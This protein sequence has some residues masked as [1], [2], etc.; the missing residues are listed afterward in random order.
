MA[1]MISLRLLRLVAVLWVVSV[2]TYL[3][4]DLIPGDPVLT[5]LGTSATPQSIAYLHQQLGL[6]KP[7][8]TR[9][10]DWIGGVLH[11][12][13][14]STLT[15]PHEPVSH[16]LARAFPVTLEIVVLALVFSVLVALPLGAWAAYRN[17]SLF[18]RAL[19]S[20]SFALV[21]L[22][23]FVLG[24]LLVL[25]FVLHGSA[26]RTGLLV[27]FCL[28]AMSVLRKLT[29]AASWHSRS[30]RLCSAGA[31]VAIGLWLFVVLPPFPSEGWVALTADPL[32]NLKFAFLPSLT[33]ALGLIPLFAQI[34]RTDM[35]GTF[36]Q[37]FITIARAK[38]MPP[39][40]VVFKEALRPSLFSL[41][42]VAGISFGALL[43]GTVVVEALFN[44]PG[45]GSA[46]VSSIGAKDYP[47]VLGA[48]IVLA[49]VF[50]VMN[51]LVDIA[52]QLLDPRT[53]RAGH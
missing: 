14:G 42:T 51:T 11:G 27:A 4:L 1:R 34:L 12:D 16:V 49:A 41:I 8:T 13:F 37:N 52:Y 22:P 3:M 33:L 24:L 45:I 18:D 46:L 35:V 7:L 53:R 21:S 40:H 26:A 6:D 43:G 17:G 20:G 10:L 30:L 5:I 36:T 31:L 39:R 29:R 47:V 28:A 48:V 9:Y 25:L 23:P 19:T 50:V 15:T 38:G 32:Q 2:C 44:L